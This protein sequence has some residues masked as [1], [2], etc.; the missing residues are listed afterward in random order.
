MTSIRRFSMRW[1]VG[2]FSSERRVPVETLA[3]VSLRTRGAARSRWVPRLRSV[4]DL[5]HAVRWSPRGSKARWHRQARAVRGRGET[6]PINQFRYPNYKFVITFLCLNLAPDSAVHRSVTFTIERGV[7]QD[8]IIS[9][10]SFTPKLLIC[11]IVRC[12]DY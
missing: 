4:S 1:T 11:F 6:K 3:P 12:R 7:P 8:D 5:G 9:P 10:I 2:M